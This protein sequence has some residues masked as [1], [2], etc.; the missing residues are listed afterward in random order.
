MQNNI[1]NKLNNV[2]FVEES[3]HPRKLKRTSSKVTPRV[4][5]SYTTLNGKYI[6]T[7]FNIY[8]RFHHNKC[9]K[10]TITEKY[11]ITESI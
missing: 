10:G 11:F 9:K 3:Y 7:C 8:F 4:L 5:S 2:L 6:M 1:E